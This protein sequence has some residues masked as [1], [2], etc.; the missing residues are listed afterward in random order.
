MQSRDSLQASGDTLARCGDAEERIR[1]RVALRYPPHR[2]P[3]KHMRGNAAEHLV[4]LPDTGRSHG[5]S[6]R[7]EA[8]ISLRW[9][10]G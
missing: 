10:P 9:F 7:P 3:L 6:G 1:I 8:A 2:E 4:E 5:R